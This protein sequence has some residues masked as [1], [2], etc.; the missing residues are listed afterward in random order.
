LILIVAGG[1]SG[2]SQ[3]GKRKLE[4]FSLELPARISVVDEKEEAAS[5]DATTS[6][7][8]AGGAFFHTDQP[9]PVGTEMQ[10]DLVLPLD[11]LK[12]LAGK[13]ASIK[14]KGAVVRIGD[15]GMAISFEDDYE[16]SSL[17]G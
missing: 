11:E 4:R 17:K 7:V 5:V 1:N 14:L 13:R 12:K 15:N 9:Y 3:L 2:M 16:I 8:S 10:V 6:D